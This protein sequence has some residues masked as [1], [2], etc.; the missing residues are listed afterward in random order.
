MDPAP[1]RLAGENLAARVREHLDAA[2]AA[3]RDFD[4]AWGDALDAALPLDAP[5]PRATAQ[6]RDAESWRE[7]L[8]WARPAFHR[9]Y[10]REPAEAAEGAAAA[11]AEVA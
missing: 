1:P 11:L 6:R 7:A 2:R 9:A 8:A 4:D 3:G 10:Y 5:H